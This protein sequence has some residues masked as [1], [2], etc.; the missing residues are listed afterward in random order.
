MLRQYCLLIGL[1]PALLLHFFAAAV[2]F[3]LLH[4]LQ[5]GAP[6]FAIS[7]SS[8]PSDFNGIVALT[9]TGL[10]PGASVRIEKHLD[11]NGNGQVEPDE[12]LLESFV[13]TD[14][15][16]PIVGG[17]TNFAIY[18]DADRT[19]NGQVVV[20]LDF[21]QTT[22]IDRITGTYLFKVID[23]AGSFSS[24]VQPFQLVST[25]LPQGIRGLVTD[26]STGQPIPLAQVALLNVDTLQ[27]TTSVF[28]DASGHF[29]AYA[30]PGNY[31]L[32]ALR[33]GYAFRVD[34]SLF[35]LAS[36]TTQVE[37]GQFVTN[38]VSL[39]P[40]NGTISGLLKDA[41]T[42][43]VIPG[44]PLYALGADSD[45]NNVISAL[46]FSFALTDETG[47]FSLPAGSST[48]GFTPIPQQLNRAGYLAPEDLIAVTLT[49]IQTNLTISLTKATTLIYGQITNQ[50]GQPLPGVQVRAS[51]SSLGLQALTVTD[52]HGNYALGVVPGTWTVEPESSSL[53]QFGYVNQKSAQSYFFD[54]NQSDEENFSVVLVP[55]SL[56][57][58]ALKLNGS[59]QFQVIGE[60]NRN[61]QVQ[62]SDD[63][64]AWQNQ[65]SITFAHSPYVYTDETA[66]G[67]RARFYRVQQL[68]Q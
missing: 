26:A 11:E 64:G 68:A 40:G 8:V 20:N 61:Y 56:S 53:D 44:L 18:S 51:D 63:L 49:N 5:A 39:T 1:R 47:H 10:A 31:L 37:A 59:F 52:R 65:K 22:E 24:S 46:S 21:S 28:D 66:Q 9:I 3:P 12:P 2:L 45:T 58:G 67:K 57:G 38:N 41:A 33:R 60:V 50:N 42:D 35:D 27:L 14:G 32:L 4:S 34:A 7:P 6:T 30:P 55:T 23:P 36:A 54:S 43:A 48:V 19:T 29:S 16:V 13:V 62:F 25:A 17:A 15:F